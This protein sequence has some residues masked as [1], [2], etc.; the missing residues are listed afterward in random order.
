MIDKKQPDSE[1]QVTADRR[2]PLKRLWWNYV[3][4]GGQVDEN[5]PEHRRVYLI[6][7]MLLFS[8][9]VTGVFFGIHLF[10]TGMTTLVI[11]NLLG[12]I[13]TLATALYLRFSCRIERV[14]T[15]LNFIAFFGLGVYL[16]ITRD[17]DLAYMWAAVYFP[18]AFFLKGRHVGGLC[19]ILFYGVVAGSALVTMTMVDP[20]TPSTIVRTLLNITA[21]LLA[22]GGMLY[23][24]E[25]TRVEAMGRLKTAQ[26]RLV[27]LST[28]DGLTGLYNR[29]H[30]DDVMPVLLAKTRREGGILCLLTLD[31]DYFKAYNDHYGHPK[32]DR[33]LKTIATVI[34]D[35]L[36]RTSDL[37]F[38]LGGEEFGALFV[39]TDRAEAVALAEAVRAGVEAQAIPSVNCPLGIITVS[40]GV[41]LYQGGLTSDKSSVR[42][43]VSEADQALYQAKHQGRNQV[44][45][46]RQTQQ[47]A[48]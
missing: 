30:F 21:S 20:T 28:T 10:W 11:I 3:T 5:H 47:R 43:L 39:T 2:G 48:M 35:T 42:A 37:T 18:F 17:Q 16:V 1:P 7:V 26:A 31:V 45:V 22:V 25:A 15:A 24:Y 8:I 27:E 41:R 13:A 12:L 36:K 34:R 4:V 9:I 40:L 46:Y 14:A 38:R 6:N 33:V 19:A 44:V 23:Y 29:R 32:G